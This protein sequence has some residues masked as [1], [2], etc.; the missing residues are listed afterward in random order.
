[1]KKLV[2]TAVALGLGGICALSGCS[3]PAQH[4]EQQHEQHGHAWGYGDEHGP[5]EWGNVSK[6]CAE[7]LNQSPINLTEMVPGQ[8]QDLAISYQG[9]VVGLTNNGH[10]L[11]AKV[12]GENRLNVDG[13]EFELKQFHFHTP[14]ENQIK[15]RS[16]PLEAHFV[17]ADKAGN[18][19]VVSVMYEI[20]ADNQQLAQLT[21]TLPESGDTTTLDTAFPVA[22]MLP[23]YDAYYRFNGSLTT[24]PCSEGVRWLVLE[25]TQPLSQEQAEQLNKVM[26]NNNRPVQPLNARKVL[27]K[28]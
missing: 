17:H 27:A 13:T 16:F 24:P 19:A 8:L 20:D 22:D 12:E 11:Q 26:G 7:G 4:E 28:Q 25:N 15:D 18:L 23:A 5:A 2:A 10:T 14:S 1:M 3:E 9:K 21:A 6:V